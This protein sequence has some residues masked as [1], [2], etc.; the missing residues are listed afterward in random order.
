[1]RLPF[2]VSAILAA[3]LGGSSSLHTAMADGDSMSS[4]QLRSPAFSS[5]EMIPAK[6]TCDG[7]DVSPALSWSEP[8][9][10]TKSMALIMDDPDAPGGTWVHWVLFDLPPN[11]R[12]LPEAVPNRRQL[13][14]GAR[15]GQNS[16]GR[17]G[18]GGPCPP[19]GSTHRYYFKLYALDQAMKLPEGAS[20]SDLERAIRGHTLAQAE[21][22]GRFGH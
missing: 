17:I 10:G 5:G 2:L 19:R 4:F 7:S 15:H 20:K 16:F 22:M 6:Y 11:T 18:Y 9:A 13:D 21:L 8:P 3:G 1:M 12:A 14:T